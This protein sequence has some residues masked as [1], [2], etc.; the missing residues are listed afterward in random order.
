MK[1]SKLMGACNSKDVLEF[2]VLPAKILDSKR[3]SVQSGYKA[4][5]S[6]FISD[7]GNSKFSDSSMPK[8]PAKAG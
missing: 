8:A 4:F 2:M 3:G 7:S 1:S 5:H 6:E